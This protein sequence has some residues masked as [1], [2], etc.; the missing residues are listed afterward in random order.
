[1][2]HSDVIVAGPAGWIDSALA[3]AACRAGA[4]GLIDLEYASSGDGTALVRKLDQF[5]TGEYGVKIGPEGASSLLS[6]RPDRLRTVLLAGGDH[7]G[8]E[9]LV[10]ELR[11]QGLRVLFEAVSVA[12]AQRGVELGVDALV[13]K[14]QEAGGRVGAEP[15]FILLQRWLAQGNATIPVYA[16]GGIGIHT[17]AA[18]VA[19]GVRGVLLDMQT[20]LLRESPLS[21]EQRQRVAALDGSETTLVGERLGAPYRIHARP[22]LPA[23]L[24]LQAEEERLATAELTPMERQQ[25]WRET[26]NRL[27]RQGPERGPWLMGQDVALA[28]PLAAQGGTVAGLLDHLL[29]QVDQHLAVVRRLKPLA[30]GSSLAQLHRT[31]YP[32]LQGPMTRV[33][34][35]APFAEAV[36]AGGGLPFLALALLRGAEC[37]ALLEETKARLGERSW[38]V[39]LLGFMPLEIRTEQLAAIRK[40]RPPF[41]IIAGGRPDQARELEAEGIVTYLHVPSPGL[42]RMFLKDGARRFI[43]EGRECGGHV[44]PR[45]SFVLWESMIEELLEHLGKSKDGSDLSVVFAGGIHD[46]RSAA[47]TAALAAPLIERKVSIGVLMGTAYL[48]TQE[49]V[50]SGAIVERF[51]QEA[52]AC[53]ETT[54]LQTAPGHAIRCVPTPYCDDFERERQRLIASGRSHEEVAR[55][56]EMMNLG[57]L[58]LASKGVDRSTNG[59][60][61]QLETRPADEQFA[62]GM[63]MIGQVACLRDRVVSVAELHEEV[64][65]GGTEF[66]DGVELDLLGSVAEEPARPPCDVAIVGLSAFYPGAKNTLEFWHNILERHYAVGEVPASHWDWRLYYDPDPRARDRIISKWGGFLT[67]MPFNPLDYGITPKSLESIEPLQLFLLEAARLAFSDAGYDWKDEGPR[68]GYE[69]GVIKRSFPRERT[70][71]ILGIGGGGSPLAV[72]YGFRTCLP[73]LNTVP[74]LNIDGDTVLERSRS[75]LPEWTEDSFPGILFNVAVGRVANRLNLGGPNYAI[76][77]ACGSSLAAVY[78]CVRELE[79]GTS[80]LAI[81]MGADTV[82][83]PYAYMAFSKTHALSPRG[84]CRPFDAEADGIVLSEGVGAVILKRLA[85]AVRDGDPIYAVIK[86]MGASSDG[87]DKGLTAPRAEGQLRALR[88]AYAQAGI[89]PAAVELIEAHGTGTVVGDQTEARALAQVLEEAGAP[90]QSCAVG[91]VKSMIGHTKCA[92][93]I[94]GLIK[95]ALALHRRTLPPTL[96][97]TPNKQ[98]NFEQGPLYLNT[99]ARPWVRSK[100]P[101]YA[102]VSAFGFGGTNFHAVL[103]EYEG[104]YE[105]EPAAQGRWPAELF[106]WSATDGAA[107]AQQ[108]SQVE[109]TLAGGAQLALA[110]LAASSWKAATR[111]PG[112]ATV[113]IVAGSL[114]ELLER[115]ALVREQAASGAK[116]FSDP[117]GVYFTAQLPEKAEPIALFPGQDRSIPTCRAQTA[118]RSRRPQRSTSNAQLVKCYDRLLARWIYPGSAPADARA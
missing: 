49:I 61:R 92:A 82:Q 91:S 58:R 17:A 100:G 52:L 72:Q 55:S 68:R 90:V 115:L 95:A 86:G 36:A 13:L 50:S 112:Q 23:L 29:A 43:F 31:R 110:E 24:E 77:A 81:A 28:A 106:V 57:R 67:D 48:F 35:V 70:A 103:A 65:R 4:L 101:R 66:L 76:D 107:L 34:D 94:A 7:P 79:L 117:R 87:R 60:G 73:L 9:R 40:H 74:G 14:G 25:A 108:L 11:R 105:N 26:I 15:L 16:Q 42:L 18:C 56:L 116:E 32:I 39:G 88:R 71:A 41:A 47:M 54:L 102:G 62:R 84:R 97:E 8:L 53:A 3:I 85:D 75:V 114:A 64:S 83:T 27:T 19:A 1:M 44:G 63:Y 10:G 118:W 99:E 37:E 96:V 2:H 51:Q 78:A 5:T 104:A 111:K 113:A 30:E 59:T 109:A 6:Q 45:T 21:H 22:G 93:G 12:E 80:D 69:P 38:G 98:G 20:M 89:S 46:A 33:S